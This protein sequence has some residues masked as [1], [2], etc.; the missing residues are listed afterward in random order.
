MEN[1]AVEIAKFLVDN[2]DSLNK[3]QLGELLGGTSDQDVE[4]AYLRLPRLLYR[5]TH[6]K[7][8]LYFAVGYL[9]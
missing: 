5:V 9:P 1:T 6:F 3:T 8:C 4:I 2:N 7:A